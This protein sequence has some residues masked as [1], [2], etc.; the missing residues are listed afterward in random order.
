MEHKPIWAV[1]R[2][3]GIR[4]DRR[5]AL[6]LE[7][8][9]AKDSLA[10]R[11]TGGGRAGEA[12]AGRDRDS[13]DIIV[14]GTVATANMR[15]RA[16]ARGRSAIAIKDMTEIHFSG[17]AAKRKGLGPAGGGVRPGF[18]C[19]PTLLVDIAHEA[20]LGVARIGVWTRAD[21]VERPK[22]DRYK[23]VIADKESRRWLEA[24]AVTAERCSAPRRP[25]SHPLPAASSW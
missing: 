20:V 1:R 24:T 3:A 11:T 22:P 6:L 8:I 14:G 7:E 21:D 12:V 23:R 4:L 25:R 17:G 13:D 15:T 5:G 18:F 10:L 9:V 16:A 2:G 19:H